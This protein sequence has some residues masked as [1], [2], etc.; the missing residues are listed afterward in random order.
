MYTIFLPNLSNLSRRWDTRCLILSYI[1]LSPFLALSSI[2]TYFPYKIF[3]RLT[4]NWQLNGELARLKDRFLHIQIIAVVSK[5]RSNEFS[6]SLSL[7]VLLAFRET[8]HGQFYSLFI[9][10]RGLHRA[11]LDRLI[12]ITWRVK[13]NRDTA[14]LVVFLVE[15]S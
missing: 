13:I 14:A 8:S 1:F 6:L 7:S 10:K 2:I 4:R 15:R 12:G 3:S 11:A 9:I 5:T